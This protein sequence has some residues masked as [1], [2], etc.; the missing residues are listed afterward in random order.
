MTSS[1]LS[2][3]NCLGTECEKTDNNFSCSIAKSN[4]E[5]VNVLTT[6]FC[7]LFK[8]VGSGYGQKR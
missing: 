2:A 7:N 1:K 3:T 4:E 5:R 6:V 8:G